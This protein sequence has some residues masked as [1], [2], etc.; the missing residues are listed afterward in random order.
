VQIGSYS[1]G[2]GAAP[3]SD[4]T[5]QVIELAPGTVP[6]AVTPGYSGGTWSESYA[7]WIDLNGDA[8]FADEGE[9]VFSASGYDT[10]SGTL[11]IPDGTGER[12]T[13]MRVSM[14]YASA[15][16]M[17][18][19]FDYGEVEDYSVALGG[20][21]PS[22]PP[23]AA[24]GFSAQGGTVSFVDAS[25]DEGSDLSAWAWDFGDG[26]SSQEQ[27]PVH[28]YAAA[29]SYSV[30]LTVTDALGASDSI[31]QEITVALSAR[32]ILNEVLADPP[33][34]TG[35]ANGDGVRNA[36][37]DEFVELYN[38][39]PHAVDLSGWRISD[40]LAV[41]FTFPEGTILPAGKA[42][43]VFGGGDPASFSDMGGSQV[44][45]AGNLSLN[46]NGDTVTVHRADNTVAD[47]L[48]YS[49]SLA[50]QT[51]MVRAVDGDPSAGFVKHPGT[52]PYSPGTRQDGQTF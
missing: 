11:T 33:L 23:V 43:V 36:T 27:S 7:I 46:N 29:G 49:T 25:T 10:V 37:Q 13:R 52:P 26:Q 42:L 48:T 44:F 39:E 8:D 12:I 31:S 21:T 30:T 9:E 40:K 32:V 35:D 34:S 5:G 4:F 41:R 15:P 17:C 24:F 22:H 3:Y 16:P 1:N 50:R 20:S 18:G 14:R 2:S 6:V 38:T 47:T 51:A 28:S 45:V 19:T